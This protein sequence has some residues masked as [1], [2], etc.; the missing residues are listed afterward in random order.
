MEAHL[1]VEE[2]DSL[3]AQGNLLLRMLGRDSDEYLDMHRDLR[4]MWYIVC[5]F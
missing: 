1:D 3:L 5:K 4:P 2:G